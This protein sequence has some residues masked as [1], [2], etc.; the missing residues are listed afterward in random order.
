MMTVHPGVSMPLSSRH[1]MQT[2][3]D[4]LFALQNMIE[5]RKENEKN[6]KYSMFPISDHI[7]L[8]SQINMH[9]NRSTVTYKAKEKKEKKRK[10]NAGSKRRKVKLEACEILYSLMPV[11]FRSHY[12]SHS[13]P[14]HT[15][16]LVHL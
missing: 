8:N 13:G 15:L 12:F 2:G 3:T 9:R 10:R 7:P 14:L 1:D 11:A 6:E 4:Q 16:E 5:R